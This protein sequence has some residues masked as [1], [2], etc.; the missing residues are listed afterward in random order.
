MLSVATE[1]A[2]ELYW[3]SRP[4]LAR[5]IEHDAA[6]SGYNG[7]QFASIPNLVPVYIGQIFKFY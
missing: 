4:G 5:I 1:P 2:R 3:L 7:L 6:M